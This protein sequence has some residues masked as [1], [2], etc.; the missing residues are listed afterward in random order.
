MTATPPGGADGASADPSPLADLHT[1]VIPGVDD[2]APDLET[3]LESLEM[4][5]EDGVDAVVG[6][7]HL[8]AS[9]PWGSRRKRAEAAWPELQS[10]AADR[11]PGLQLYRGFEIQLDV[12]DLDLE[13]DR[14]RLGGSRYAL[15]EFHA[16]TLPARSV[17]ALARVV[18]NGFV[19]VLA[20]PERYFGYDR[21]FSVVPRWRDVG[22]VIQVNSGS[23]TGEYGDRVRR[24]ALTFLERGW[25]DV[26]ASDNHGRPGRRPSLRAGWEYLRAQGATDQAR[27]LLSV[28]PRRILRDEATLQVG[29]VELGSGGWFG[30][31][32]KTLRGDG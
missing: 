32:W 5:F 12:P 2:G 4:L 10:A 14:L 11:L 26:L 1:H 18:G 28:N 17:D 8:N 16:F 20:H 19:P 13:D 27:L 21:D 30:K 3:A 7:P 9:N 23:L 25:V 22:A 31:V 15:V 29:E 6:T 24:T